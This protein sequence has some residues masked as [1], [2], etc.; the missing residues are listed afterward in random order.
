MSKF[1]CSIIQQI[2]YRFC[3]VFFP[4]YIPANVSGY[5]APRVRICCRLSGSIAAGYQVSAPL[6]PSVR[7][8]CAVRPVVLPLR[9][10]RPSVP[11]RAAESA[12][13]QL[14][15]MGDMPL[16]RYGKLPFSPSQKQKRPAQTGSERN[17]TIQKNFLRFFRFYPFRLVKKSLNPLVYK[18][19]CYTKKTDTKLFRYA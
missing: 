7:I 5:H 17:K 8:C 2:L 4:V 3:V 10:C 19:L 18:A 9:R 12:V 16:V 1:Y 6:L 14:Y 11:G 13:R 15:P